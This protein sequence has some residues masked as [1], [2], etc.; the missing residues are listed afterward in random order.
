MKSLLNAVLTICSALPL[1]AADTP[2]DVVVARIEGGGATLSRSLTDTLCRFAA[3]QQW[4]SAADAE[5]VRSRDDLRVLLRKRSGQDVIDLGSRLFASY[6][7]AAGSAAGTTWE[8][9]DTEHFR[10]FVRPASAASKDLDLIAAGVERSRAGLVEAFGLEAVVRAREALVRTKQPADIE[11]G[12]PSNRIAVYLYPTRH[13]DTGKRVGPRSMGATSFGA[14]IDEGG[15]G[16][17]QP[18]IHILYYSPFS[19]AVLEHEIAHTIVMMAAFDEAAIDKPL[20]GEADL[21]KAFFAGYRPMPAFLN[22]GFAGYGLYYAGFYPAWGLLGLPEELALEGKLLPLSK[23]VRAKHLDPRQSLIS[24]TFLRYLLQT[25]GADTVRPWLLSADRA[26]G[27]FQKTMGMTI[28]EAERGW[29][30]W[31]GRGQT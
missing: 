2:C 28:E 11:K 15:R 13:D 17:L 1:A 3:E 9:R 18:A 7:R 21:K 12:E 25:K 6:E 27:S 26:I 19:L 31:L 20:S 22:E 16:R 5:T 29:L 24:A 8:V 14:T 23:L 10:L 4:I 30:E